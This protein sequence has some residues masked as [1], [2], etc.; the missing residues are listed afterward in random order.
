MKLFTCIFAAI[1]TLTTIV[2]VAFLMSD[3]MLPARS[4]A[5]SARFSAAL[6]MLAYMVCA[7][8]IAFRA[9]RLGEME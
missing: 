2:F 3:P 8:A 5:E 7:T 4:S 9:I 6:P 1:S